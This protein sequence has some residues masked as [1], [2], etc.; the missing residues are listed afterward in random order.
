MGTVP[1]GFF[2]RTLY[3]S[4]PFGISI[5]HLFWP[6]GK[7][8]PQ[9]KGHGSQCLMKVTAAFCGSQ[10]SQTKRMAKRQDM[11]VEPK[12]MGTPPNHEF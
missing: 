10:T 11:G 3:K 8:S 12:I 1:I 6:F 9:K 2:I 7:D 4:L 5:R